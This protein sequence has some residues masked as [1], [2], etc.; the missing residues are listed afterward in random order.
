LRKSG[1]IAISEQKEKEYKKLEDE[2]NRIR[3]LKR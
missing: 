2:E 3:D 1:G